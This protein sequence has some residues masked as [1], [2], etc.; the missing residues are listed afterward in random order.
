MDYRCSN[1]SASRVTHASPSHCL[2]NQQQLIKHS[3][4]KERGGEGKEKEKKCGLK[5]TPRV[6]SRNI[7]EL[8][9]LRLHEESKLISP[10]SPRYSL[11]ADV[12]I[13]SLA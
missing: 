9:Y 3:K 7:Y 10:K 4:K 2:I 5:I 13:A 1:A 6:V 11:L 12:Q 8:L